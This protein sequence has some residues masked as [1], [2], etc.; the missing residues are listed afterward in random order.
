M[1]TDGYLLDTSVAS[2]VFN[3]NSQYHGLAQQNLLALSYSPVYVSSVTLGEIEYGLH[4]RAGAVA[5]NSLDE[6]RMAAAQYQ[7]LSVDRHTATEYGKVRAALFARYARKN[8][9]GLPAKKWPEDLVDP[10]TGKE[11]GVQENDLWI[12]STAVEYNLRLVTNDRAGGMRN[13][14]ETAGYLG[15]AD[16]WGGQ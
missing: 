14:L 7:V 12:V 5:P 15:H 16:F 3:R 10:T 6:I 8:R 11:L 4:L 2:W 1:T 13:I 9:R